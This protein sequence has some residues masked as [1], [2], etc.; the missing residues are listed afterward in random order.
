MRTAS[1]DRVRSL[2]RSGEVGRYVTANTGFF[3]APEAP[4]VLKHGIL[5]RYPVVFASAA[6]GKA[7]GVV[8]LDG[9]AGRGRY[10]DGSPGSPMLLL[11]AASATGSFRAV[12]CVFVERDKANFTVLSE[13]VEAHGADLS[14][15]ALRG[16]L[17]SHLSSILTSA[18]DAALF[19]FLDP[20]GTAL[21]YHELTNQIL[22]RPKRPPTE[23]LLH[24]SVNAVRRIGGLLRARRD[25]LSDAERKTTERVD[26][27][28]GGTWW[29]PIALETTDEPG[30]ATKIAERVVE[31]Y[32]RRV[33]TDTGSGWF[34]FPV[35]DRPGLAAEY[36]L[37]LFTRH[38]YAIWRFNDALSQA[39]IEWQQAW[40]GKSNAKEAAKA[41]T[42]VA[43]QREVEA[44]QG[45]MSLLDFHDAAL[46][47]PVPDTHEPFNEADEAVRWVR[48]IEQNLT[49]LFRKSMP[50][51]L[52]DHT[53]VVYGEVLGEA[54]EKHVA[55]ALKN[56]HA[57]GISEDTG[58][59]NGIHSRVLR[60]GPAAIAT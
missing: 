51:K 50:F 15:C 27:F 9:Y 56:L 59:G 54:R 24:F 30:V 44:A 53:G 55:R 14:C 32:C 33:G 21:D 20:F 6:G 19:A 46:S 45:Q 43:K 60:P 4:A 22:G 12:R 42:K 26:R 7:A 8:L 29:H 25:A 11:R 49:V 1:Q 48:V 58:V 52:M 17:S 2:R 3:R 41:A 5:K 38:P 35:R 16:D 36:F 23:V 40:R 18:A 39:N 13:V 31:E 57:L 47:A 34:A 10:E 37:V 28:L